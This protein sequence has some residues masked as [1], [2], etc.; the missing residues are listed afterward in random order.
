MAYSCVIDRV[1]ENPEAIEDV[2]IINKYNPLTINQYCEISSL[3]RVQKRHYDKVLL[4]LFLRKYL[5]IGEKNIY[6][7]LLKRQILGIFEYSNCLF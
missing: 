7:E 5:H 6:A 3:L 1:D 4:K 2:L